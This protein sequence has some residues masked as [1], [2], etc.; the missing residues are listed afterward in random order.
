MF[1]ESDLRISM[2]QMQM[3]LNDY[4]E[5]PLEALTYLSGQCNYGGRVTDDWDRRLLVSLLAMFY[6]RSVVE[7]DDYRFSP[8]GIYYAPPKGTYE[9]Y[10]EYIKALP[11]I[12]H[13]EIFGLHAN[14]DI[15]KDQKQTNE[16]F[17]SI[18]LTQPRQAA[19]KGRS[20]NDIIDEL[21]TSILQ[22]LPPK[23]SQDVVAEK[24]PVT[25]GESMNTV[26]GQEVV[27]FNN[28]TSVIRSSLENLKK[29]IVGLVVMSSEL[30]DVFT[31]MLNGKV[32]SLWDSRSYPSL[33]PL[34]GYINDLCQRLAFLQGWIDHGTP[35]TF[36]LSGFFFTQAFLTGA[37]Q[38][39][40]RRHKI[41]IDHLIFTFSILSVEAENH[42]SITLPPEDGVYV[43]GLFLEGAR[44]DRERGVLGES[45][46]K[47]LYDAVPVMHLM[48][49]EKSKK[50][51]D[52]TYRCP[53]YKTTA[54]R[55]VLST[56]GHS[57]NYVMAVDMPTAQPPAHWINRG[58]AMLCSL[59]D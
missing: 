44:W 40:A 14:A 9:S 7:D 3:F 38:N 51:T 25:Y 52:L 41:P 32:P 13:P 1:N 59:N 46:S 35:V 55:G 56:T 26:L 30:E 45:L 37:Q 6:N 23:F 42:G 27:R 17:N 11:Q 12:P 8:S 49:V 15:S 28:L 53:L 29:A 21:A 57:T 18:L 34:G 19:G 50:P 16:L 4:D 43:Y 36:W 31:N 48:P 5:L 24:F 47:V 54:R 58:T 20:S 39:F 2:R 33:K 22:K 10:I